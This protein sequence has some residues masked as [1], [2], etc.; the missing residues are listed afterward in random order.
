MMKNVSDYK[1]YHGSGFT[2]AEFPYGQGNFVMDVI[3]P[4]DN[5]GLTG[6]IP[7]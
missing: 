2:V 5:N 1:M 3:L 4:D 7:F 6:I